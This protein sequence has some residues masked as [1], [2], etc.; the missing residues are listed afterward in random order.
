VSG[1]TVAQT[2]GSQALDLIAIGMARGATYSPA[3]H[4]CKPVAAAYQF[5]VRFAAW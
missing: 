4:D 2:S 5:S 3:L 1:A